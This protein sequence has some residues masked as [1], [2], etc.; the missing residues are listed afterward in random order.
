M[1][2]PAPQAVLTLTWQPLPSA[3]AL[4]HSRSVSM[5]LRGPSRNNASPWTGV[6]AQVVKWLL[7]NREDLSSISR[8][9]II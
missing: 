1:L 5:P 9:H 2:L 4:N 6:T 3:S 8:T 7:Y